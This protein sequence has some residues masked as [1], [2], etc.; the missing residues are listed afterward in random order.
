MTT[1]AALSPELRDALRVVPLVRSLLDSDAEGECLASGEDIRIPAGET[2]VREGEPAE[3]F[4]LVLDGEARVTKRHGGQS[5]IL[6]HYRPGVFLGEVPIV[7]GGHYLASV[8]TVNGCRIFRLPAAAFWCVLRTCPACSTQ[9]MQTLA[10]RLRALESFGAQ[11]EKLVSL[12]TMAAGLA[13]EL[14]NPAAAARRAAD[15]LR[16][17]IDRAQRL[18][19]GLRG[20]LAGA[21]WEALVGALDGADPASAKAGEKDDALARSDREEALAD[22]LTARGIASAWELAPG[23][24]AAGLEAGKLDAL[25]AAL[26]SDGSAAEDAL[27]WLD[28]R[29]ATRTL[30]DEMNDSTARLARLVKEVKSY[31]QPAPAADEEED[32]APDVSRELAGACA[33][34]DVHVSIESALTL[35]HH[36]LKHLPGGVTRSFDR[37]L[38]KVRAKCQ[39][40]TQVWTNLLDNA[41]DAA[42]NAPGKNGQVRVSTRRDGDGIVVEIADN[43]PGIP[44]EVQSHLFEPFFTTKPVG[45]GTGLGLVISNRII[46]DRHGGEIEY[47]SRPGDTR[48]L[49]RLPIH[50]KQPQGTAAGTPHSNPI[51]TKGNHN[52]AP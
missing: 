28:A 47:S 39:E 31:S 38:P 21:H 2:F 40:L 37:A 11:R 52:Y 20:R 10:V 42:A 46:A 12:G 13:H 35:L 30:L 18:A 4:F 16:D 36:K 5:F 29:L 14:N 33:A 7:L 43:G 22:T 23:F 3:Y 32:E 41:A 26:P 1:T 15:N 51:E 24:A 17:A 34:I 48:F 19:R 44:S 25:L 27:R 49:A 50:S 8:E 45:K 6:N 9:I